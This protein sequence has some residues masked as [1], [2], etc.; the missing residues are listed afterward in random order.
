M[1]IMSSN[2]R[3][4]TKILWVILFANLG[5]AI[6]KIIIGNAIG[7]TSM[8]ADGFH[9]LTDGS[10]NIVGIIGVSLASKPV[11]KDHP[12]GHKK[13]EMLA[14]LFIAVMLLIIGGRIVLNSLTRFSNPIIPN[15]TTQS[16]IALISTLVINV[17]VCTYEYNEGK[18]LN[19]YIL[20]SDSLHTKSDIYVS[21]GVLFT[22]I[23]IRL[24]LPSIVDPLASF[25]VAFFIFHSSYEI[26]KSTT[27]ILVDRAVVD[28]EKVTE[29][30]MSFT[31]VK[32]VH[33][34]RSRGSESDIHL[35][36]HIMT[37]PNMSVEESHILTHDIEKAI[38]EQLDGK[39][40][41]IVHIEPFYDGS[42][43]HL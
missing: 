14:G 38:Q 10:S 4:V 21:I 23:S 37:E 32:D 5:V 39:V 12:Y 17:L 41:V 9:S 35:D 15:I 25:V 18:R 6:L 28:E 2:Y 30:I 31:Q 3:K 7:S 16:L 13:F 19:S 40:Q 34:V 43:V 36:M 27:G 8:A 33:N 29:I 22:L 26:F 1:V 11:D 42:G 20:M 24:G